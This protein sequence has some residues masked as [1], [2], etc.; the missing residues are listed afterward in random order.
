MPRWQ[1]QV[2][3]LTRRAVSH[4]HT[5]PKLPDLAD[6]FYQHLARAA[7]RSPFLERRGHNLVYP[8]LN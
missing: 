3:K 1:E 6:R 4:I 2:W 5:I 7:F 8:F